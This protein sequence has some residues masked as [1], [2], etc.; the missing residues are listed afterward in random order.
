MSNRVENLEHE[1]DFVNPGIK[2]ESQFAKTY[3][4]QVIAVCLDP[5]LLSSKTIM[6]EAKLKAEYYLKFIKCGAYSAAKGNDEIRKRLANYLGEKQDMKI[7]YDDLYLTYG[8]MDSY[9]HVLGLFCKNDKV[10][11]IFLF[12]I[13]VPAACYPNYLN[14]N[15]IHHFESI[16]Y[17]MDLFQV[18]IFL[19]I[20]SFL[21]N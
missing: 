1:L 8:G 17:E 18:F 19:F 16:P 9:N 21:E 3:M 10:N 14:Y 5:K 11:I 4:N 13:L 2:C 12:K 7:N 6:L 20:C 15:K